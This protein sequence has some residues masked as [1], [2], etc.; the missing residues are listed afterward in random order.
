MFNTFLSET[1]NEHIIQI[2]SCIN[3]NEEISKELA[4]YRYKFTKLQRTIL[5]LSVSGVKERNI[6]NNFSNAEVLLTIR[7]YVRNLKLSGVTVRTPGIPTRKDQPII[8]ALPPAIQEAINS[9]A[10]KLKNSIF[11]DSLSRERVIV[12][13]ACLTETFSFMVH[14]KDD[15]ILLASKDFSIMVK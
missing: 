4:E 10:A 9:N 15:Y 13:T 8:L 5:W 14:K 7:N 6:R 2:A 3:R 11:K 1:S 12:T